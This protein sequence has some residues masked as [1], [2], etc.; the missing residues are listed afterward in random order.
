MKYKLR[1]F[2]KKFE[3]YKTERKEFNLP[4]LDETIEGPIIST[5]NWKELHDFFVEFN[6]LT[7]DLQIGLE[8]V[9]EFCE[10]E[11]TP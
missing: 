3:I 11:D 9:E 4:Y 6:T 2:E 8:Y 5:D 10:K 7:R 1:A